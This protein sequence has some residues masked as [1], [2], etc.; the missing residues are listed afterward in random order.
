[1][2]RDEITKELNRIEDLLDR[3]E[4]SGIPQLSQY[5]TLISQKE[6]LED[7]LQKMQQE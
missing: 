6:A 3:Q 4:Q 1:M 2:S 7:E 5:Y